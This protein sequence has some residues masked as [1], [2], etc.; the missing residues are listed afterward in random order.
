[1]TDTRTTSTADKIAKAQQQ[2]TEQF[3]ALQTSDD[4]YAQLR[5]MRSIV[6]ASIGAAEVCSA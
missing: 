2:L 4:C 6:P 1:M 5:T 3:N